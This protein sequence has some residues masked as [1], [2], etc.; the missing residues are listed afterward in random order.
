MLG[1]IDTRRS[2]VI[3]REVCDKTQAFLVGATALVSS[4]DLVESFASKSSRSSLSH[5]CLLDLREMKLDL[6]I[7]QLKSLVVS[8][9]KLSSIEQKTESFDYLNLSKRLYETLTHL[10]NPSDILKEMRICDV[11]EW[12]WNGING[13]STIHQIYLIEKTHPLAAYVLILPYELHNYRKFFESMGVRHQ[14]DSSKIEDL[15]RNQSISDE[16][17]L[18]WM[19]ETYGNDRRLLQLINDV[20]LKSAPKSSN[21]SKNLTDD[22]TR[23]TFSSTL[24][25]SDDKVYLYLPGKIRRTIDENT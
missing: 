1:S 18:K 23:I 7:K 19:K 15:L 17:L 22:Q 5:R 14:P 21:K 10:N 25:L 20:E 11:N 12:I 8:Y 4:L 13:Y 2:F 3:P 16:N 9:Q 6:L 24:D